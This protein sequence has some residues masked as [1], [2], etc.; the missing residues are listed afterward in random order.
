MKRLL[1]TL[2]YCSCL[3]LHLSAQNYIAKYHQ[4]TD[5]FKAQLTFNANEWRYDVK[6]EVETTWESDDM[7]LEKDTTSTG[8][9][10]S[11]FYYR[12]LDKNEYLDEEFIPLINSRFVIRGELEKPEWNISPDSIKTIEGYTCL[13]AKGFVRG[14]DYAVWFTPDI[15]VSAG[16]WK[17]WGLPG[18]IVSVQSNGDGAEMTMTSLTKTDVPPK[19]PEVKKTVTPDEYKTQFKEDIKKFSRKIQGMSV[20]RDAHISTEV[21]I[22][23]P[24]KTL[25]D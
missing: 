9:S 4:E 14:R 25:Y 2:T 8:Y 5:G 1:I 22:D 13:M 15:P 18:L 6:G 3:I 19:R 16:P 12:S 7:D 21:K 11:Q 17:L 23:H 10:I 24:D 20:S